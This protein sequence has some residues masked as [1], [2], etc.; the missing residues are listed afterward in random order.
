MAFFVNQKKH[1]PNASPEW[2]N[3]CHVKDDLNAAMHQ[4]HAFL[5]TYAY[6]QDATVDY[7][8]CSVEAMDGRI[9]KNE[10]DDRIPVP[11]PPEPPEP[12]E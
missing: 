4:F 8:A 12:E 6:G 1:K 5:S 2:D 7:C 3:G 9:V 10:V 11:E